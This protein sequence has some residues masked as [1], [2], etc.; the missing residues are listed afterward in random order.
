MPS[1]KSLIILLAFLFAAALPTAAQASKSIRG[2]G[3]RS[4]VPSGW[5]VKHSKE[6]GGWRVVRVTPP[7]RASKG[8]NSSIV[9]IGTVSVRTL[10]KAAGQK[11]PA[12]DI[13]LAQQLAAVPPTAQGI[14]PTV[15][16]Q[17]TVLAGALGAIVGY[18]YIDGRVGTTQTATVVRRHRRVYLLQTVSDDSVSFIGS[19]AVNLVRSNWRWK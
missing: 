16:P 3:F 19:Q 14:Q 6:R 9:V 1:R 18:H 4:H 17:P 11:L 10:E 8:R 5:K 12:S 13:E 2:P 7:G 15:N